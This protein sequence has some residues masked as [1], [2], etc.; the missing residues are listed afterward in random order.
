[1]LLHAVELLNEKI[2]LLT[3]SLLRGDYRATRCWVLP[4]VIPLVKHAQRR[5]Q[6]TAVRV[7]KWALGSVCSP[8]RYARKQKL[9]CRKQPMLL[10][11]L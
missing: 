5:H 1:R 6:V 7:R 4:P 11:A 2:L 3:S 10:Q 8:F 9:G